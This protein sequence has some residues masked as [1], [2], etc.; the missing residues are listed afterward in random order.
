M[1]S[2]KFDSSFADAFEGTLEEDERE[3][4]PLWTIDEAISFCR[5]LR[6]I[7]EPIGFSVGLTG[8]CLYRGHSNKDIDVIFYPLKKPSPFDVGGLRTALK[9]SGL[10]KCR[11]DRALMQKAWGYRGVNDDKWV[12]VWEADGKRVDLFFME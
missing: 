12:E 2:S 6:T 5:A 11:L 7:A 1:H 4:K 8:G 10:L 9:E 3:K